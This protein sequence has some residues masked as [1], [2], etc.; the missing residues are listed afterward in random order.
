MKN[1]ELVKVE[2]QRIKSI[3]CDCC[4]T[5]YPCNDAEELSEFL[6]IDFICGYS[7]IFGDTNRVQADLCQTCVKM[8]LGDILRILHDQE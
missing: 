3:T 2:V 1:L 4:K 8:K 7:S 5:T 6:Y